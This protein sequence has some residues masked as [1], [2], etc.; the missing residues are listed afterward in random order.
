MC[1]LNS[2]GNFCVLALSFLMMFP[3]SGSCG[4]IGPT[5]MGPPG[6]VFSVLIPVLGPGEEW[7]TGRI[8][9]DFSRKIPGDVV[10]PGQGVVGDDNTEDRSKAFAGIP[11]EPLNSRQLA[12]H[13]AEQMNRRFD[14]SFRASADP[15][16]DGTGAWQL[17][18]WHGEGNN[19]GQAVTPDEIEG[20]FK[21][22]KGGRDKYGTYKK[23]TVP[24]PMPQTVT[25]NK[26]QTP[27]P[28][29]IAIFGVLGLSLTAMRRR[30]KQTST[31][32]LATD[33]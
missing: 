22:R 18:F 9:F 30:K 31:S 20:M 16:P 3:V 25:L 10:L 24:P 12:E 1:R 28:T 19:N 6:P 11:P 15:V 33:K 32:H 13:L 7:V 23:P 5:P 27:E 21:P 2:V 8:E 26:I 17:T 29:S 14:P 4:V